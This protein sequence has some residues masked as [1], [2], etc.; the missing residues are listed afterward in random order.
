MNHTGTG[1]SGPSIFLRGGYQQSPFDAIWSVV[2]G[3]RSRCSAPALSP[4]AGVITKCPPLQV[5]FCQNR[6]VRG[7]PHFLTIP[8]FQAHT[9]FKNSGPYLQHGIQAETGGKGRKKFIPQTGTN[10][11]PCI[12][13]HRRQIASPPFVSQPLFFG[14]VLS[15]QN[16]CSQK[17]IFPPG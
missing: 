9:S 13:A 4:G 6:L 7:V 16:S 2:L 15:R 1:D 11:G 8:I 3:T 10:L 17:L 12:L 14:A 5:C